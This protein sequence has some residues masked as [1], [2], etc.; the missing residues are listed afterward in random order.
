MRWGKH[1]A[2]NPKQRHR[3]HPRQHVADARADGR[4]DEGRRR[5]A[6]QGGGDI[7]ERPDPAEGGGEVDQPE[8]E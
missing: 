1:L 6:D 8:R 7:G 2:A 5:D 4:E 3:H